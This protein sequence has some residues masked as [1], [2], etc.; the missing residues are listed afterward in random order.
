MGVIKTYAETVSTIPSDVFK[1]L[2][3][4]VAETQIVSPNLHDFM[5]SYQY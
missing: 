3:R 2:S 5:E 1:N 4:V